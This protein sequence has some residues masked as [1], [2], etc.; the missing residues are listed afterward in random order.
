LHIEKKLPPDLDD[1][2]ITFIIYAVCRNLNAIF[3]ENP[4]QLR[5]WTP[6]AQIQHR[7]SHVIRNQTWPPPTPL[8]SDW[9]NS[10]C[11]CL[12]ILHWRA[13]SKIA[14]AAG[15]EHA[16]VL[17]LHLARLLILAPMT[18]LQVLA[19]A[20]SRCSDHAPAGLG[21]SKLVKARNQVLQWALRDQHKARLAVVHAG[22]L[23]W[24]V[25][26][27]SSYSFVEPFGIYMATLAI[28]AY[29]QCH[30]FSGQDDGLGSQSRLGVINASLDAHA[31]GQGDS[32][33]AAAAG[34]GPLAEVDMEASAEPCL[35]QLD[36]PCDDEI[37]QAFVR[38]GSKMSAHMQ[39]IGNLHE[40]G[41]SWKVL[42]EGRRLLL[43]GLQGHSD[44]SSI[45]TSGGNIGCVEGVAGLELEYSYA[46]VLRDMAQQQPA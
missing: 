27:F 24:H 22:A 20:S 6:T 30:H 12:D 17:H 45:G 18:H 5:T 10:A 23:L 35:I 25:R 37:V 7:A 3:R 1:L 34:S 36:R 19:A 2:S 9:R 28:W 8:L 41:A 42:R 44:R 4:I 38:L 16:N 14:V 39:G 31:N 43:R 32:P 26:R 13:N 15:W 33:S 11:D 46:K 21:S 29:S 40:Q